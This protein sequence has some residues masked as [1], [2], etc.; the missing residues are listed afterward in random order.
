MTEISMKGNNC[1]RKG[2]IASRVLSSLVLPAFLFV[3]VIFLWDCWTWLLHNLKTMESR[4]K[5]HLSPSSPHSLGVLGIWEHNGAFP[6]TYCLL[7]ITWSPLGRKYRSNSSSRS[8][9]RFLLSL[10]CRPSWCW[11]GKRF[12]FDFPSAVLLPLCYS[13][14]FKKEI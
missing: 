7:A 5:T 11:E 8:K 3:E 6:T 13:S 1:E 12:G 10:Q 2:V 4:R 9:W 14:S